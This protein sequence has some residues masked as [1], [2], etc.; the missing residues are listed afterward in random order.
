MFK[1]MAQYPTNGDV[2]SPSKADGGRAHRRIAPKLGSKQRAVGHRVNHHPV[3]IGAIDRLKEGRRSRVDDLPGE[4][5]GLVQ[6][7]LSCLHPPLC[8]RKTRDDRE[9]AL[10]VGGLLLLCLN[11]ARLPVVRLRLIAEDRQ[12][13]RGSGCPYRHR[14]QNQYGGMALYPALHRRNSAR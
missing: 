11:L 1:P 9:M 2:P 6:R 14:Y 12:R 5:V 10:V 3:K 13:D 7:P 8:F 4:Q